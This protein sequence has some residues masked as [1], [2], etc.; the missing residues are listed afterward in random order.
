MCIELNVTDESTNWKKAKTKQNNEIHLN[1]F[2]LL[3]SIDY[4]TMTLSFLCLV[5][6]RVLNRRMGESE[7]R[8]PHNKWNSRIRFRGEKK[9]KNS[10][11]DGKFYQIFM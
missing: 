7:K 8:N 1:I 10:A 11:R 4:Y 3:N 5:L 9:Q 2:S 6:V